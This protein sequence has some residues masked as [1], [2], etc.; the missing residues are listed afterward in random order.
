[1]NETKAIVLETG[2]DFLVPA[3]SLQQVLA[4]YQWKK[5]FIEN[6]LR[7]G[8]DFG[9]TPGTGEK[10]SLKKPGAEKM[11]SFFGLTPVFEDV[12]KVEDW[13]GEQHGGESFFY[14]RQKCKLYRGERL[15]ATA[16]GSCNSWEKKYR[17]RWVSEYEIPAGFDRST[18]R[19]QGGKTSE[20]VFAIDKAETGG[21]YGKPAEYWKRWNDAIANG[22]ATAIKRKTSKGTMMDAWEMDSTVY[23]VPNK[24][25]AEQV[26]TI[27]KMAQKR[28][29][30][31]VVLIATNASDYFTQDI[32]DFV[33]GDIVEATVVHPAP[34]AHAPSPESIN[35]ETGEAT[36][37]IEL[38]DPHSD[39]AA[40]IAMKH[41]KTDQSATARELW[42][43]FPTS[44]KMTRQEIE[45]SVI[46]GKPA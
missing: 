20:F 24:D 45:E 17:Y 21:K 30:V 3:A 26:N 6:V 22:T 14:Y 8:V 27:L 32:D 37:A 43:L 33:S 41:W 7:D 29:L 15:I 13:T 19:T 25:V 11:A 34:A 10:P 5:E 18:L 4:T 38:I 42:K 1:M 44:G 46:S 28:A 35:Q 2:N 36:P 31:A 9:T 23:A 16:D 39:I 12:E 40:K